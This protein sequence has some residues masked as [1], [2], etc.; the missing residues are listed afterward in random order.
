LEKQESASKE[1]Q[2]D[3]DRQCAHWL[4]LY[5]VTVGCMGIVLGTRTLT[6]ALG[7]SGEKVII[8]PVTGG[9]IVLS[10]LSFLLIRA[11]RE[12][13]RTGKFDIEMSLFSSVVGF[14]L[15]L[16]FPPAFIAW[17]GLEVHCAF[18]AREKCRVPR[19]FNW[20]CWLTPILASVY[21]F[22]CQAWT[23]IRYEGIL[24]VSCGLFIGVMMFGYWYISRPEKQKTNLPE[25]R[26]HNRS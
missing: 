19:S 26:V 9:F 24:A 14:D 11:W 15:T 21:V 7:W 6:Y 25:A 18:L 8:D 10:F 13:R 2:T 1:T 4:V 20:I 23:G 22:A 16:M 12:R 17:V 5:F 3:R